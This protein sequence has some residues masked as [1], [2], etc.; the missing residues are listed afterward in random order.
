MR[1]QF[2]TSADMKQGIWISVD[3]DRKKDLSKYVA[4]GPAVW[5]G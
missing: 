4:P 5:T 1:L 2:E 3:I